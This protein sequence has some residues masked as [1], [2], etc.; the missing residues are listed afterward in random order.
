MSYV[1]TMIRVAPD[2]PTQTAIIPTSKGG[3][4]IA[5]LEYE[6]LMSEPYTLTQ[7]KVQFAVHARHKNISDAEL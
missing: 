6:L 7:D 5:V 3:K 2:S 1:K 4:T